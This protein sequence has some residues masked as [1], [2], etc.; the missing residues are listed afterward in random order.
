VD[1]LLQT[2]LVPSFP[3]NRSQWK[4]LEL[5]LKFI[6]KS[7][8]EV[9]RK[10]SL[11]LGGKTTFSQ[12]DEDRF[13]LA[14]REVEDKKRMADLELL[15]EQRLHQ[16]EPPSKKLKIL[17]KSDSFSKLLGS[18]GHIITMAYDF[19]AERS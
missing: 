11:D 4:K 10:K 1:H 6:N 5:A 9:V 17:G 12:K 13:C 2:V 14:A 3:P 7:K 16:N 18:V 19:D 8:A 15:K